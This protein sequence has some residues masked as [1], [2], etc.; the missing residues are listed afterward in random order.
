MFLSPAEPYCAANDIRFVQSTARWG[1]FSRCSLR[2][3]AGRPFVSRLGYFAGRVAH[4]SAARSCVSRETSLLA[5]LA[6]MNLAPG[7][8]AALQRYWGYDTFRPLQERI[9]TGLLAG[10][11]ACVIMPTGG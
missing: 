2:E 7:P 6:R 3:K 4:F 11:D 10:R 8:L 9:I 1:G 5:I